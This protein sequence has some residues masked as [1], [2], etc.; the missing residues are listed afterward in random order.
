MKEFMLS[1]DFSTENLLSILG[2]TPATSPELFNHYATE[3]QQD[4]DGVVTTVWD[5]DEGYRL[6]INFDETFPILKVMKNKFDN[7]DKTAKTTFLYFLSDISNGD[8]NILDKFLW[9][10]N[11]GE[12][13]YD[14]TYNSDRFRDEVVRLYDEAEV[15]AEVAKALK[16]Q[17]LKEAA[18]KA[19]TGRKTKHEKLFTDVAQ[20]LNKL[21][22]LERK[23]DS[24]EAKN[25]IYMKHQGYGKFW[26]G[27]SKKKKK[28]RTKKR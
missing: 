26:E 28:Y 20:I 21:V 14:K 1:D 17:E 11:R 27:G 24:L 16:K 8:L 23:I 18:L 5:R 22:S 12:L 7:T 15:A 19:D 13:I 6:N 2:I 4:E 9:M 10:L 3:R 25:L